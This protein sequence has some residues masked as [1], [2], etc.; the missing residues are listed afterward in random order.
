MSP[1]WGIN[2]WMTVT[3]VLAP[4]SAACHSC[5]WGGQV[6]VM[7]AD[8][9]HHHKLAEMSGESLGEVEQGRG[10]VEWEYFRVEEGGLGQG[11]GQVWWWQCPPNPNPLL[12]PNLSSQAIH[13]TFRHLPNMLLCGPC[14][15]SESQIL[16]LGNLSYPWH[17]L[18]TEIY[19][20]T[21][22]KCPIC[23]PKTAYRFWT[24]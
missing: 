2:S 5:K 11:C 3:N 6:H 22:P 23:P 21:N 13:L 18:A 14:W 24:Q 9:W 20:Q 12:G 15:N 19:E 4:V 1:G 7:I 8:T 17:Q 16:R 10:W